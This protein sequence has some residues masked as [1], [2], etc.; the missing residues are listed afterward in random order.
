[1]FGVGSLKGLRIGLGDATLP[2]STRQVFGIRIGLQAM[3][4]A[5]TLVC[6]V[7]LAST[8]SY[9]KGQFY[10]FIPFLFYTRVILKRN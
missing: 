9:I 1:M 7:F 6:N 8:F 2:N 4:H 10:N 5:I 3:R